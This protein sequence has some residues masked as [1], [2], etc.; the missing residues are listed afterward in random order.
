MNTE[1]FTL[2]GLD[3]AEDSGIVLDGGAAAAWV[4]RALAAGDPSPVLPSLEEPCF[5]PGEGAAAVEYLLILSGLSFDV[6]PRGREPAMERTLRGR[7]YRGA[8][9]LAASVSAVLGARSQAL[10]GGELARLRPERFSAWFGSAHL[11]R[12]ELRRRLLVAT[13]E[14]IHAHWDGRLIHLVEEANGSA[15]R[16]LGL[17]AELP[18]FADL[19]QVAGD[20]QMLLTGARRGLRWIMGRCHGRGLGTW[21][22]S[23]LMGPESSMAIAAGLVEA[24]LV[25]VRLPARLPL[26]APLEGQLRVAAI[27]AQRMLLPILQRRRPDWIAASLGAHFERLGA[28]RAPLVETAR[29]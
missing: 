4:G 29:Y 15:R 21:L 2:E 28:P 18:L 25:R 24:G 16:L 26:D 12:A 10:S 1:S 7:R 27:V 23:H 9:A 3:L 14:Q 17:L 22:D 11:P 8:A 6:R 20:Q 5:F 13:G 19:P